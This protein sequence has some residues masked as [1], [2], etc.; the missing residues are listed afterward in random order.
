MGE[1]SDPLA[2]SEASLADELAE[3]FQ[4]VANNIKTFYKANQIVK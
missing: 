3:L 2:A 1:R 4:L